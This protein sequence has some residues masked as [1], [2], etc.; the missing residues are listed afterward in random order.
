[1]YY[2]RNRINDCGY[3][4]LVSFTEGS[5]E[6]SVDVD[7]QGERK[8]HAGTQCDRERARRTVRTIQTE[9]SDPVIVGGDRGRDD[10]KARPRDEPRRREAKPKKG[11]DRTKSESRDRR[12]SEPHDNA[13]RSPPG[14]RRDSDFAVRTTDKRK[15]RTI[16][17]ERSEEE[18]VRT[19]SVKLP[20]F[21][22]GGGGGGASSSDSSDSGGSL[23]CS[24]APK[25]LS[26]HAR[27]KRGARRR[28]AAAPA[29]PPPPASSTTSTS[30]HNTAGDSWSTST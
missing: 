8:C 27:H 24:L 20:E 10:G 7:A 13:G 18:T 1:M 9:T 28:D 14:R 3:A 5:R 12:A 21:R 6:T 2:V 22:G 25:W 17:V 16:S 19:K 11:T 26:A 29:S 23:L 4:I 15:I 30:D